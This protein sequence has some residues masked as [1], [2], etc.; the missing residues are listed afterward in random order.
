MMLTDEER[1][2]FLRE[3]R[4]NALRAAAAAKAKPVPT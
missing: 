2:A 3:C 1:A 4:E